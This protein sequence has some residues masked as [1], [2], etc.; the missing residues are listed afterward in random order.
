MSEEMTGESVSSES[1][2][3]EQA[4]SLY[5]EAQSSTRDSGFEME[6]DKTAVD[7]EFEIV[8]KGETKKLP[9]S[10]IRD[11]AQQGFDYSQKMSE[12]NKLKMESEKTQA[13]NEERWARFSEM[14]KYVTENPDW[15]SHVN[16]AWGTKDTVAPSTQQQLT[17]DP[18]QNELF[19]SLKNEIDGLKSFKN[20]VEEERLNAARMEDDRKYEQELEEIQKK[21]PNIDFNK[22]GE[23][24]ESLEYNV[25]KHAN[26]N[27]I[28]SFGTAFRDYYHDNLMQLAETKA[29]ETLLKDSQ[30]VKKYGLSVSDAPRNTTPKVNGNVRN[31]SY[32]DLTREALEELGLS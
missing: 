29:K 11:L 20:S 10:K 32:N 12:F 30:Q 6:A 3:S 5:N 15:W 18:E 9:L 1:I 28:K 2:S 16:N 7:P 26:E 19:E 31:K 21:Y 8:Y 27:G 4:E 17:T 22:P 14:D 13:A 25:L 24:G 23:N